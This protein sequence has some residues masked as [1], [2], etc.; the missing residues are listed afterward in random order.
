MADFDEAWDQILLVE[1]I[2]SNRGLKDGLEKGRILRSHE[3]F[4]LG[5]KKGREI[6]EEIGYYQGFCRAWRTSPA[7]KVSTAK[8][9]KTELTLTKLTDLLDK[10]PDTNLKDEDVNQRL[11]EIRA[12]F[13]L[14][15]TLLNLKPELPGDSV[16]SW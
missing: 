7:S 8:E 14:A 11:L 13:K 2:E 15:C 1:D 3:G 10:F 16:I 4:D 12:K 9:K 5:C 6:G